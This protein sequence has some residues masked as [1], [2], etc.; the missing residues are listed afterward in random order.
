MSKKRIFETLSDDDGSE[1]SNEI[2]LENPPFLISTYSSMGGYLIKEE[3]HD[4]VVITITSCSNEI[5]YKLFENKV[6]ILIP[7]PDLRHAVE[8]LTE[9]EC[10]TLEKQAVSAAFELKHNEYMNRPKYSEI[11]IP[12]PFPVVQIKDTPYSSITSKKLMDGYLILL[13]LTKQPNITNV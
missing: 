9:L 10:P 13:T 3:L 11:S 1:D 2:L 4:K 8:S 12:L 7:W 6:V 5:K